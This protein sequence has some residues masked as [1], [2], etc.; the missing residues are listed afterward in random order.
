MS[1][2]TRQLVCEFDEFTED[3]LPN[4]VI[5]AAI[6]VLF[7]Y[8][9]FSAKTEGGLKRIKGLKRLMDYL[10]AVRDIRPNEIRYDLLKTQR[11]N[12]EYKILL[13]VC[14]LLFDGLLMSENNGEWKLRLFL[15]DRAMHDLYQQF[16]LEYF[17][18]HYS[19]L[20]PKAKEIKWDY[21][22]DSKCN[23]LPSMKTDITMTHED[24]TI[25]IDTKYH[26]ESMP[27]H[28]GLPTLKS[29]DIYQIYS[30][31]KNSNT[32]F[33]GNVAGMLLY[34]KTD[35]EIT[36]DYEFSISGSKISVKTLDL[37]GDFSEIRKQLDGIAESLIGT[38]G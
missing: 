28:Q 1:H 8:G 32:I 24:K 30:Y 35:E 5:K 27:I 15:S 7:R 25:I 19:T 37:T 31:V 6:T 33:S 20:E 3:T 14:R 21:D 17:R 34:A 29:A 18:Y 23:S 38:F 36:P 4:R 11:V 26:G 22:I 9:K 10:G 2:M 16:V 12:S 13:S